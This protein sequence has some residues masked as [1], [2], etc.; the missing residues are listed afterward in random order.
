MRGLVEDGQIVRVNPISSSDEVCKGDIV[1]CR[2]RG[3]E[4]LHLVH[5]VGPRGYLIGSARGH[6]NGWAPR[7]HIFGRLSRPST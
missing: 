1:L 7:S 2:V 6:L 5:A 3:R 4:Y